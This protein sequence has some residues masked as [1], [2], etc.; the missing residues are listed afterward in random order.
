MK[1]VPPDVQEVVVARLTKELFDDRKAGKIPPFL[2]MVEEA[3]NYCPERG[4]R[5]AVSSNILRT[6]ASEG[7]KFGMGLCIISQ[8]PAKVDK[9]IISQCNTNIILKVTN[10]NDLKTIIQSVEGLTA[11]TY[12]EIQRLPIG[13]ALISGA[14]LQLPVMTEIRTRETSHGGKSIEIT[15][16]EEVM[17]QPKIPKAPAP[18][19]LVSKE[20]KPSS[21]PSKPQIKEENV[22]DKAKLVSR[23][24][25]R[26][27][28]VD[29]DDPDEA[30]KKLTK[31]AEKM[32]ENVYK[33]LESLAR[34]GRDFCHTENPNCIKCPMNNGCK[35]SASHKTEKKGF[36]R[37]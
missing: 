33:Y 31:E 3:H 27:G 29:I 22:T 37:R 4:F 8:R 23:V 19:P 24:A 5:S 9:N 21:E 30:I 6:I 25:N 10:P 32:N 28:W 7:R 14:G 16:I 2:F 13:V 1:G 18:P 17:K 34:L 35:Y 11:Q 20:T 12:S 15:G 36:F 26:L